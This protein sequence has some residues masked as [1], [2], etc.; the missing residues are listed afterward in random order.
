MDLNNRLIGIKGAGKTTLLLQ[1][2]KLHL[3]LQSPLRETFFLNQFKG[4]H[5]I[6]LSVEADFV[7]DNTYTFEIAGKNKSKPK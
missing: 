4:L 1:L 5:E 7:I 2:A 6:N 3:P